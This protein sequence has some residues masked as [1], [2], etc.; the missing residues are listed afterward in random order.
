MIIKFD[1]VKVI[2]YFEEGGFADKNYTKILIKLTRSPTEEDKKEP[3]FNPGFASEDIKE[4]WKE[5]N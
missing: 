5:Y 3:G 1:Q 4:E 2:E